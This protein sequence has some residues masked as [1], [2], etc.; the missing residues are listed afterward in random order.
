MKSGFYTTTSSVVRPRSSKAL[1]KAKLAPEKDQGH[2]S[3][4]CCQ[5]DPLQPSE[6]AQNH[7]ISAS[8]WDA[9]KTAAPTAG[10]GQQEGPNSSPWQRP[11]ARG[12]TNASKVGWIG[13][14]CFAPSTIF[15]W[16]L[17]GGLP[18]LQAFQQLDAGEMF[19]QPGGRKYF[20]RVCRIL[21]HE[22]LCYRN[23]QVYFSLAKMCWLQWFLYW[24][25]K[26]CFGPVIMI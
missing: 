23:K 13:L 10:I 1:S 22:F 24:L 8:W 15:T 7:Y 20:P 21:K 3:V 11:T 25:I 26:K 16:P 17:T 9:L 12:T 19:P 5:F 6:S 2:C 14:Q 18:L 4:V